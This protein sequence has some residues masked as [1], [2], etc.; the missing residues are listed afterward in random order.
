MN[1][2]TFPALLALAGLILV[3]A[4][5]G[6]RRDMADNGEHRGP[7]WKLHEH[8]DP[9]VGPGPKNPDGKPRS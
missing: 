8:G 7:G 2:T 3:L 4:M 5:P 6:C 1:R 9:Q